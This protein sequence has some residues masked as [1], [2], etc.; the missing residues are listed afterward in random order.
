VQTKTAARAE[1]RRLLSY[2]AEH[3]RLPLPGEELGQDGAVSKPESPSPVVPTFDDAVALYRRT[4]ILS[5]KPNTQETYEELLRGVF[6]APLLKTPLTEVGLVSFGELDARLSE[7]GVSTSRRRNAHVVVRS[8][9]RCAVAGGLLP[10]LPKIPKLPK[11]GRTEPGVFPASELA[12]FLEVTSKGTQLAF[13]LSAYA[14]L[15][16][17]EI[18]GLR[19]GDVDLKAGALVVRRGLSMVK[20]EPAPPKSGHERRIPL[21]A[22][23]KAMLAKAKQGAPEDPVTT[24]RKGTS[25]TYFGLRSAFGRAVKKAGLSSLGLHSLRHAFVTSLFRKEVAAPVVQKL[26]GH[27][28]L[29]VTQLYAHVASDELRA[30]V[31]RLA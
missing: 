13:A 19:W 14:G 9:L 8:V 20:N 24:S 6:I 26:A 3:G 1:E 4:A 17:G 16:A 25:W 31:D 22:P 12:R 5:K 7:A 10:E 18:R 27:G 28:S 29:A 11:V 15:R 2:L 21:A 23:L 30:A